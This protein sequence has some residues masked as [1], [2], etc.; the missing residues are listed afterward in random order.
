MYHEGNRALQDAFG[1]RA[2]ADRLEEKL[3]RDRFNDADAEFIGS[4]GFFFLATADARGRP[5][6]S[7]KGGPVGFAQV[8]A[9]DLLI[10]PDYD[11]NGMFKS[12]GNLGVNP[13]VG[14]LFMAMGETPKRLRV[15]GVAQ[16]VDDDP[17]IALIPGA[18]LLVKVTPVDIFPNC[19][20]Y[21]PNMAL[22]APSAYTP[23]PVE[24]PVEPAWKSFELFEGVVPPRRR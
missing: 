23:D 8:V 3:R 6:C 19:P 10:F 13:H 24:A 21:V 7:F 2:L 18:Q 1:S 16:V 11:G 9:P 14:I 17:R 22:V 12:L 20:R 5:D 4:L 15:N